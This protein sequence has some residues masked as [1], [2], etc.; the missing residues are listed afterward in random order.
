MSIVLQAYMS[1]VFL[2]LMPERRLSLYD[3][4]LPPPGLARDQSQ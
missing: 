2:I 4:R 3:V 1:L